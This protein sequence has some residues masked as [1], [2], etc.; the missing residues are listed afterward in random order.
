MRKIIL[1][2]FL[3][4][5]VGCSATE[6]KAVPVERER[7]SISRPAPI[8]MEPLKFRV[9]TYEKKAYFCLDSEGYKNLSINTERITN[10]IILQNQI[11]TKYQDYYEPRN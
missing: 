9:L 2:L 3:I 10:Y 4:G 1:G 8:K 7:L 6:Y 11:L 5:L